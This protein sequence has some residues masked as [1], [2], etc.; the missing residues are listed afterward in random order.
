MLRP[1]KYTD[2]QQSVLGVSAELLSVLSRDQA[3]KFNQLE[4]SVSY[5]LGESS[6]ENLVLAL[7]FLYSLGKIRYHQKEDIVE[8][9]QTTKIKN[10]TI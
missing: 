7:T 6:K 1:D 3:V 5:K 4:E 2:I 8:L 10:E 9:I